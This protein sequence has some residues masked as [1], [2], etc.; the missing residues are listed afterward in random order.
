MD[1]KGLAVALIFLVALAFWAGER[2]GKSTELASTWQEQQDLSAHVEI[3]PAATRVPEA[4]TARPALIT[5]L[6][7]ELEDPRRER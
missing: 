5:G 2:G 6:S 3:R 1:K 7:R 4:E